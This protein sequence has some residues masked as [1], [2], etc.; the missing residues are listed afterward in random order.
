MATI[1]DLGLLAAAVYDAAPGVAGWACPASQPASGAMDGFQAATFTRGG[2]VVICYRG[3]SQAMDVAADAALGT[4]MN[5][6]YFAAGEAYAA[7]WF[8]QDNVIVCGHSLGG[9][10]AQVVANRRR[11]RLLT[12]NAPGVATFA[13][14]NIGDA[15]L[16]PTAVR[17]AGTL[18]SA[19]FHPMQAARDIKSAFYEVQGLNLCL[20]YDAVSQIGVHYGEVVRI[21]GTSMNPLT[22]HRMATVNA[23]LQANPI[24]ARDVMFL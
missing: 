19:L 12:F 24:G 7:P 5:S 11:F 6:S 17:A 10:I 4:G 16:V 3:T 20:Q 13:S 9:A 14:R 23:V 22:E 2:I 8:G 21:P 1:R 18:V 15:F